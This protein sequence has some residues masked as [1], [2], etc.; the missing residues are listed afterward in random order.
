LGVSAT[1][2]AITYCYASEKIKRVDASN[3]PADT[4]FIP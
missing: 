1:A 2:F 4:P 3:W